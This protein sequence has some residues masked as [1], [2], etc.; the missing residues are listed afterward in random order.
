[1]CGDCRVAF[2]CSQQH[3]GRRLDHH[4]HNHHHWR[5]PKLAAETCPSR[6]APPTPGENL[7]ETQVGTLWGILES[8]N[9]KRARVVRPRHGVRRLRQP[10]HHR[11]GMRPHSRLPP[12]VRLGSREVLP[13][14]L[15]R[16]NR[17]Q[18]CYDFIR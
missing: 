13:H 9:Y 4:H 1:R 2:Y 16:L 14:L 8:R 5:Q 18:Q 7:F 12:P 17:D 3:Q 11:R 6:R 15:L 10:R